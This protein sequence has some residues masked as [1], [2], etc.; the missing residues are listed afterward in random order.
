MGQRDP[1]A[2][3]LADLRDTVVDRDSPLFQGVTISD[4][5]GL[6]LQGLAIHGDAIRRA[7]FV[8]SAVT[9][10]NG[11]A[12]VVKH[13]HVRAQQVAHLARF[14]HQLGFV[15]EQREHTHFV[16]GDARM[17]LHH[18]AR[19]FLALVVGDGLLVVGVANERERRTARRYLRPHRQLLPF[20]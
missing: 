13:R 2:D 11:A 7:G 12:F 9:T 10:A 17:K 18:N 15:F 3:S 20:L 14:G 5:D 6:I 19:L 8:L 4:R 1:S 16:R